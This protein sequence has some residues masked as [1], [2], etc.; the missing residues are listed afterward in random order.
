MPR[1]VMDSAAAGGTIWALGL[2]VV[3][4]GP[5]KIGRA[6]AAGSRIRPAPA[7]HYKITIVTC[8]RRPQAEQTLPITGDADSDV[9][10]CVG[11]KAIFCRPYPRRMYAKLRANPCRS[12]QTAW[13]DSG[14]GHEGEQPLSGHQ[15]GEL[16]LQRSAE[17]L[18]PIG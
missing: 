17:A 18:E 2:R 15:R 13:P 5:R 16:A 12:D 4:P 9:T 7:G 14:P 3:G 11:T 1:R 10:A 8:S 6:C